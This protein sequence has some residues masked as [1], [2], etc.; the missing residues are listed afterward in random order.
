MERGCYRQTFVGEFGRIKI[1]FNGIY[2]RSGSGQYY[3]LV[4]VMVRNYY[5]MAGLLEQ[6]RYIIESAGNSGHC[7]GCFRGIGHEF[8]SVSCDTHCIC[9]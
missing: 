6:S 3:L 9:F 8:A 7:S 1:C 2:C 4:M 5:V